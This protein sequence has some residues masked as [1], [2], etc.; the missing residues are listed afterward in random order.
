MSF[1]VN[2]KSHLSCFS[3]PVSV[4]HTFDRDVQGQNDHESV[5]DKRPT[6]Y[7]SVISPPPLAPIECKTCAML[8]ALHVG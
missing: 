6:L 8:L 5:P 4:L 1:H 7:K 3:R 2:M